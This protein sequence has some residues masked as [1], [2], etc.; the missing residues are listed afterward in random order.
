MKA[1][2]LIALLALALA[3]A[4]PAAQRAP[5][6][7]GAVGFAGQNVEQTAGAIGAFLQAGLGRPIQVRVYAKYQEILDALGSRQLDL[8][9]LTPVNFVEAEEKLGVKPIANPIYSSGEANY[10][11]VILALA[12]RKDIAQLLDLRGKK[13]AFVDERSASGCVVPRGLLAGAGLKPGKDVREVFTGN[14]V[15]SIEALVKGEVDAAATYDMLLA[16]TPSIGHGMDEFTVLAR[17][18]AIPGEVLV[19][20]RDLP[21][22]DAMLIKAQ[23]LKFG[24]RRKTDKTLENCVYQWFFGYDRSRYDTLRKLWRATK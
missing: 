14:H 20:A 9:I 11:G 6:T 19:G 10:R 4:T 15:K 24:D 16:E 5:L 18:E 1:L 13:I 2:R 17:S 7:L 3:A 12:K 22:A 23:L 21:A 8:A